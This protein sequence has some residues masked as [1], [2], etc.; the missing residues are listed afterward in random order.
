MYELAK[1]SLCIY[2]DIGMDMEIHLHIHLHT[3]VHKAMYI[4]SNSKNIPYFISETGAFLFQKAFI[5]NSH[6]VNGK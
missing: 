4:F 6:H 3:H 5:L 1:H 2:K